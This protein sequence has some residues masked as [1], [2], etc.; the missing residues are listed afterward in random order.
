MAKQKSRVGLDIGS[1]S[2][3]A[4]ELIEKP[5]GGLE[6]LKFGIGRLEYE[7]GVEPKLSP[8]IK[9]VMQDANISTN[10]INASVSGQSVIVRYIIL[11]K[12]T[13]QELQGA[14]RFEAEKYIPFDIKE[15]VLDCQ[16]LEESLEEN[17]MKVLLVAAKKDS[18][19]KYTNA[20]II[21][22]LEPKLIDVDSFALINSF[23]ANYPEN[24]DQTLALL[25]LG[26]QFT[27]INILKNNAS[28]FTRDIQ[29][30]GNEITNAVSKQLGI[31]V[32]EAEALKCAPKERAGEVFE[33]AKTV[34][35]EIA[36]E[37][38]LSFDY[39][40][41]QFEKGVDRVYLSGGTSGLKG[42]ESY[43]SQ[44]IGLET[45]LWDPTKCLQINQEN[46]KQQLP[47]LSSR[48]A[49]AIGLALRRVE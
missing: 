34:L 47:F 28:R 26:A 23:S 45:D 38:R 33:I 42:I 5:K 22:G 17:K 20:I 24:K 44:A 11:P 37:I 36:R 4:V 7:G 19:N 31:S 21:A 8:S 2:I 10:R 35:E 32:E 29:I 48:L 49:V 13:R 3:K 40:E 39:Y 41:S 12:M 6:L 27:N 43:I 9:K 18:I 14:I 30:A 1:F 46:L 15:V 16:V 25:N